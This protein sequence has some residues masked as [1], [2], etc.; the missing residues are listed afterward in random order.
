MQS[1]RLEFRPLKLSYMAANTLGTRLREAS[2]RKK[3]SPAQVARE[4][5]TTEA[6]LSNWLLDKV[7][8]EHLKAAQLFRIADAAGID[9]RELL[10]NDGS[11]VGE[12]H[13]EYQSQV[14]KPE[15]L[16]VAI[17]LVTEVLEESHRKLPPNR[18]AEAIQLAYELI[19]EDLPRAKVL[20]FVLAAVA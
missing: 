9:A 1:S 10:L 2:A 19:E 15:S 12:P 14:L 11:R 4:A 20:R 5:G 8:I 6:T 3:V 16:R 18:Q 13:A 7:Q 17:Q